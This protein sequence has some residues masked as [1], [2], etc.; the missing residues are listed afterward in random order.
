[1]RHVAVVLLGW[2]CAAQVHVAPADTG[3]DWPTDTDAGVP[4]E[5]TGPGEV[6]GVKWCDGAEPYWQRWSEVL[7]TSYPP[8]VGVWA[9]ARD[10]S[11]RWTDV[12]L[13]PDGRVVTYCDCDRSGCDPWYHLLVDVSSGA[14][15]W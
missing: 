6:L 14:N 1:M 4:W 15:P 11:A 2:G 13:D 8:P 9:V 7:D 12:T 10:G 3:T 5:Y